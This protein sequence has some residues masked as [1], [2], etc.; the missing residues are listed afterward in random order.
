MNV[1]A[2]HWSVENLP[3]VASLKKLFYAPL[4]QMGVSKSSQLFFHYKYFLI[5][6]I[7][8]IHQKC[9]HNISIF[10]PIDGCEISLFLPLP[11]LPPLLIHALTSM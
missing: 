9:C 5:S 2:I 4:H 11:M 10:L 3:V 6:R 8:L 7:F 1:G